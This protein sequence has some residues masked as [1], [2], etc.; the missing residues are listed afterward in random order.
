MEAR[1][2]CLPGKINAAQRAISR[3]LCDS[4]IPD[5][6]EHLALHSAFRSLRA[7]Q[8]QERRSRKGQRKEVIA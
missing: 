3:R 5:V 8:A 6:E 4:Q 2:E 1:S 7:L